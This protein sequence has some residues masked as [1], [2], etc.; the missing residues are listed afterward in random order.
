MSI[1]SATGIFSVDFSFGLYLEVLASS[2]LSSLL[3][4]KKLLFAYIPLDVPQGVLRINAA[5]GVLLSESGFVIS[6][7]FKFGFTGGEVLLVK[8]GLFIP[9]TNLLFQ[10]Q[11]S[12]GPPINCKWH[13]RCGLD[14]GGVWLVGHVGVSLVY[15]L[16]TL[17]ARADLPSSV[18]RRS[19]DITWDHINLMNH[20]EC[21]NIK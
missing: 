4:F 1:S 13:I 18:K 11:V 2:E 16:S 10:F 15:T 19:I 20:I 12:L 3:R 7:V 14:G 9:V 5:L 17:N 21:K 6:W 8:S